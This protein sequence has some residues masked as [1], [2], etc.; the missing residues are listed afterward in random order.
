MEGW[1]R[2]LP[3]IGLAILVSAVATIIS[4]PFLLWLSALGV[5]EESLPFWL[6]PIILFFGLLLCALFIAWRVSAARIAVALLS[7]RGSTVFFF[8]LLEVVVLLTVIIWFFATSEVIPPN[9]MSGASATSALS[10]LSP[11]LILA[12]TLLALSLVSMLFTLFLLYLNSA[13]EIEADECYFMLRQME[14]QRDERFEFE[15]EGSLSQIRRQG[16][17]LDFLA[18]LDKRKASSDA[19]SRQQDATVG[20]ANPSGLLRKTRIYGVARQWIWYQLGPSPFQSPQGSGQPRLTSA[21]LQ[22]QLCDVAN[23]LWEEGG[24]QKYWRRTGEK[25]QAI[26]HGRLFGNRLDDLFNRGEG[27]AFYPTGGADFV[28]MVIKGPP[29]AGKSTLALQMCVTQAQQGNLCLYFSLEDERGGL[30]QSARNFG[31]DASADLEKNEEEWRQYPVT[32]EGVLNL[33]LKQSRKRL[34]QLKDTASDPRQSRERATSQSRDPSVKPTGLVLVSSFGRR[35][36]RMGQRLKQVRKVWGN[37]GGRLRPWSHVARCVVIDSLEGFANAGLTHRDQIGVTRS[38]LLDVKRFFRHR[39]D[40]L[41]ILVEDDGSQIAGFSEFLA[42]TVISIGRREE[43]DYTVLFAEIVKARNQTHAVGKT[44]IKI[45]SQNDLDNAKEAVKASIEKLK[46]GILVFP[47]LHYRLFQSQQESFFDTYTLST[48]FTGFDEMLT[49]VAGQTGSR[50]TAQEGGLRRKT[51]T[52]LL[53]P[54]DTGKSILAMNFLIEGVRENS[55]TL[56]LSLREDPSAVTDVTVPQEEGRIRFSWQKMPESGSQGSDSVTRDANK[57]AVYHQ[58]EWDLDGVLQWWEEHLSYERDKIP[59]TL[60]LMHERWRLSFLFQKTPVS[61]ADLETD[62]QT[63][64]HAQSVI[65]FLSLLGQDLASIHV[66]YPDTEKEKLRTNEHRSIAKAIR[67][68][69]EAVSVAARAFDTAWASF[70]QDLPERSWAYEYLVEERER[71]LTTEMAQQEP[72]DAEKPPTP[73]ERAQQEVAR[74]LLSQPLD[75][76]FALE[77]VAARGLAAQ[78]LRDP[79]KKRAQRD[80]VLLCDPDRPEDPKRIFLQWTPAETAQP[81]DSASQADQS[82]PG[83]SDT[84]PPRLRWDSRRWDPAQKKVVSGATGDDSLLVVKGFRPGNITADDFIDQVLRIIGDPRSGKPSR[85]ERVVFDDVT[86][87]HQRF[88]ILDKTRL[89]IPTLIDMFKRVL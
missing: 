38:Q 53:G 60:Q 74:A 64:A 27:F 67:W 40:L 69:S 55:R 37:G 6:Q 31:W 28:T 65:Q 19:R 82:A 84:P 89:F 10:H 5:W 11:A 42:D 85:F 77:V 68:N 13:I 50:S 46:P 22:E 21:E 24:S 32:Y 4:T 20:R 83:A 35:A 58:L 45:R 17:F 70:M 30:V 49:P 48:G 75:P 88:P 1:E 39:C 18:T 79:E 43:D 73:G 86:Q 76:V 33:P 34:R 78:E 3:E 25:A 52:T 14:Y 29:G 71:R 8:G 61:F 81:S 2:R 54:R 56:L 23:S 44:Q 36:M 15:Q 16:R 26:R 47:S 66:A 7:Q 51:A 62:P 63:I 12:G 41:V 57:G 87:L 72:R 80:R 9:L 59:Y